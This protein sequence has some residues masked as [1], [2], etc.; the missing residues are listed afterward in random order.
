[1]L[2]AAFKG[3]SWVVISLMVGALTTFLVISAEQYKVD[4]QHVV[5]SPRWL[6]FGAD[7]LLWVSVGI[8][9]RTFWD[10]LITLIEPSSGTG[11]S[12]KA[13]VLLVAMSILYMF[14][15]LP[16]RYLFLVEDYQQVLTWLQ[17]RAAMLPVVWLVIIG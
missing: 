12:G 8:V 2:R 11:I 4:D 7:G 13:I 15:Y 14:F 1:M 10:S 6:E 3:E 16:S 9:T 5:T 17:I